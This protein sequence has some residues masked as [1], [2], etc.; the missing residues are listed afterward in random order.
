MASDRRDGSSILRVLIVHPGA[1]LYGSDRMVAE[2]A[3]ALVEA[4]HRVL[5]AL[6]EDGPLVSDLHQR[7]A[8]TLIMTMPVVRK[9]A[10]RPRG[11]ARLL[12]TAARSTPETLGLL[13]WRPDVVYV[14]TQI[15]PT[16]VLAARLAGLHTVCH[17]HEAERHPVRVVE[18][19]L[20]LPLKAA[21]RVIA[22]S[23]YSASVARAVVPDIA[24]RIVVV[25]NGVPGPTTAQPARPRLLDGLR[26]AYLGRLSPRKGVDVAVRAVRR[27]HDEGMP[28]RLRLLGGTFDGYEWYERELRDLAGPLVDDGSVAFVGF[29]P[30]IWDDLE[31]SDVVVVPSVLPEPFGNTAVE[32]RLAARPVL[33]SRIGGLPEAVDG[34]P[35]AIRVEPGSVTDLTAAL[36][37]I[38]EDWT[39]FARAA[40]QDAP[41]CAQEFAP[42]RYRREIRRVVTEKW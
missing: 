2:S 12:W 38:I 3:S 16:W 34:C 11:M 20:F 1:E 33:V 9:A 41:R 29:R 26:V 24:D 4:G 5:V 22:N 42:E 19:G 36:H 32:A 8:R 30:S 25:H 18:L 17:V 6:P 31:Q 15:L 13:R 27:L 35:S 40:A 39:L 21:H 7:G 23:E 28:I 37:R 14:S 10:L